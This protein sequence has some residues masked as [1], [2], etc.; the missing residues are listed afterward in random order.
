MV[1]NITTTHPRLYFS[2]TERLDQAKAW[3]AANPF[4]PSAN[5]MQGHALRYLLS[6]E[7]SDAQTAIN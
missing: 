2:T 4:T 3:Y 1:L 5:D 6:G 7:V